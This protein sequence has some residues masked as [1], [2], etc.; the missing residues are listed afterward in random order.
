MSREIAYEPNRKHIYLITDEGD[1]VLKVNMENPDSYV[2][3]EDVLAGT[4][5]VKVYNKDDLVGIKKIDNSQ[6]RSEYFIYTLDGPV[7]PLPIVPLNL[8]SGYHVE[9]LRVVDNKR[10]LVVANRRLDN[11]NKAGHSS[12]MLFMLY[13][14]KLER[15]FVS[16]DF[17]ISNKFGRSNVIEVMTTL[18]GFPLIMVSRGPTIYIL[19]IESETKLKQIDSITFSEADGA[20]GKQQPN[21]QL[22]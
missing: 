13:N 22:L 11:D 3:L 4:I 6:G 9:A 15:E 12:D 7:S 1:S 14:L 10:F 8:P 20:D 17:P 5:E 18:Q 16:G 19:A 2:G 21:N